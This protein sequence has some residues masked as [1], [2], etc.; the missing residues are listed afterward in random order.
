MTKSA[1]CCFYAVFMQF[2]AVF[3]FF[4]N[5]LIFYNP[6]PEVVWQF[7]RQHQLN[8]VILVKAKRR[9]ICGKW[10][11]SWILAVLFKIIW[12]WLCCIY[13]SIMRAAHK[14]VGTQNVKSSGGCNC[15]FFHL[16]L[17]FSL[18]DLLQDSIKSFLVIKADK[19]HAHKSLT[20]VCVCLCVCVCVCV[21][22]RGLHLTS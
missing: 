10:S 21:C 12:P 11:C 5:F 15:Y 16:I 9:F 7:V 4:Q 20:Q 13:P 2:H 1:A 14:M 22:G 18:T 19:F 6:K 8:M 3:R 17:L